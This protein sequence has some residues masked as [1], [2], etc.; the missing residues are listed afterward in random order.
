MAP[1]HTMT[2]EAENTNRTN[3]TRF[4]GLNVSLMRRSLW[5]SAAIVVGAIIGAVI[6]ALILR[7]NSVEKTLIWNALLQYGGIQDCC[8]A[9][10]ARAESAIE[11]LDGWSLPERVDAWLYRFLYIVGSYAL[12][13]S[14]AW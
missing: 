6:T 9:T 11:T 13:L 8:W 3:F 10:L 4:Y 2:L 12:A 5:I 1:G 7:I 14:V